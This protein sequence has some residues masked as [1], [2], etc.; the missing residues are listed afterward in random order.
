LVIK[1]LDPYLIRIRIRIG[2]QHHTLDPDPEKINTDPQPCLKCKR[3]NL[4]KFSKEFKNFLPKKLSPSS[5]KY[6][7]GIRDPEKTY[8]GSRIQGLKR[9]RIPDPDPKH[10]L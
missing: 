2:L 4:G 6:G 3:L 8:S 9:H 7:F 1:A 5:Q 10:C